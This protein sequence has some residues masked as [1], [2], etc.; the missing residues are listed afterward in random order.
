[1]VIA[2]DH[3]A[4]RVPASGTGEDAPVI[5]THSEAGLLGGSQRLE[6]K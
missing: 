5:V 3:N 1:M 4:E 6:S 2:I